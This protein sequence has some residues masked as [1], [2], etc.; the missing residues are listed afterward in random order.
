MIATIY[1]ANIDANSIILKEFLQKFMRTD[2]GEYLFH[3]WR[4]KD[5]A[6]IIP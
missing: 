4:F 3:K 5:D 1:V 6:G 2:L